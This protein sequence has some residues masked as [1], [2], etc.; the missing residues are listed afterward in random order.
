MSTAE[1]L[2]ERK[3]IQIFIERFRKMPRMA[4][5]FGDDVAAVDIG[6]GRLAVLK[7][8]ML[9]D[10]TDAPREMTSW[11][12][13]RK[14]VVVTVSDFAS[15][16]VRPI[17]LLVSVGLPRE[18]TKNDIHQLALGMEAGAKEYGVHIIGGD[19][20][21]TS[22]VV[23]D[24]LGFGIAEKGK[25][26]PRNGARPGD[27]LAVTG[28]F[29]DTSAGL[30]VL[31]GKTNIP[32]QLQRRL[33]KTVLQPKAQL[34]LG[35]ALAKSGTVT[36]STD[37]SDGLAW[38]LHELSR[39]S[40]VGFLLEDVPAS[41]L[42]RRFAQLTKLDLRDLVLY[43]GEEFKLVLTIRPQD[44]NTAAE[45]VKNAGGILHRIGLTTSKRNVTL[46]ISETE[47]MRIRPIGWEH[48]KS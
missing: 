17:A 8:D 18:F 28:L 41:P 14:A 25:L 23:I 4:L 47:E 29:G 16:G 26:M 6:G 9:V 35:I 32:R 1:T 46:R 48:F 40:R 31:L 21:E 13:G 39:M 2:G 7:S 15:K 27:I 42:A 24:C 36:S 5:P 33:V 45:A 11:Q 38:S 34:S 44:W 19:T 20:D 30:R 37:S 22:D 10:K 43:G 3:I 12:I